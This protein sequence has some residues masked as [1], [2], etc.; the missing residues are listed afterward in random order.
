M[1]L[2]TESLYAEVLRRPGLFEQLQREFH[3]TLAGPA[4]FA[5]LLNAL[6]M[7]FRSLA[8]EQRS[9]EVWKVLGAVRNEFSRYNE[10]VDRLAKQ[11]NTAAESVSKLGT[12]TR[13]MNKTLRHV[14]MMPDS[15][16]K[17]LIGQDISDPDEPE[18]QEDNPG[19]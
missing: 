18:E 16:A 4:T 11:L 19:S 3:V 2:P 7:G 1:F 5:A 9:G 12:R 10:V 13:S 15:A 14:E 17:I 6:Q 8:L